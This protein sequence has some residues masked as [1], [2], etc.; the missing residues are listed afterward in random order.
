LNY[1]SPRID[2]QTGTKPVPGEHV[3]VFTRPH[4]FCP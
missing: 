4:D 3:L 2:T 1:G